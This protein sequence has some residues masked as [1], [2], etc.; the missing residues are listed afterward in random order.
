MAE[1]KLIQPDKIHLKEF[2]L[3]NGKVDS[4]YEFQISNIKSFNFKVDYSA[5]FNIAE[6]LIKADFTVTVSTVSIEKITD[7]AVGTYYFV[8]IFQVEEL[9]EH[10]KLVEGG[11]FDVNPYLSNAIASITYSTS[12]GILIS[13]FQGTALRDFLLPVIDPNSLYKNN[14]QPSTD[15]K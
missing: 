15:L 9:G 7:E 3:V 4:P 11:G 8:F 12:R 1:K 5:G 14:A 13:R 10:A 2:R 6:N